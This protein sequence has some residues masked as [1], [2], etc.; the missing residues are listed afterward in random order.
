LLR[1]PFPGT[2]GAGAPAGY[3]HP[4]EIGVEKKRSRPDGPPGILYKKDARGGERQRPESHV[5]AARKAGFAPATAA[6]TEKQKSGGQGRSSGATFPA[7]IEP[8]GE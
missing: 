7:A 2:L 6:R 5:Y 3:G 8:Y 1:L 4:S